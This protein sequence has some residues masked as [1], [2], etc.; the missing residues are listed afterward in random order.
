MRF[1]STLESVD[2]EPFAGTGLATLDVYPDEQEQTESPASGQK[3]PLLT[4]LQKAHARI[5]AWGATLE[6]GFQL[7]D[8][9]IRLVLAERARLLAREPERNAEGESL[10]VVE[11]VLGYER[12]A[13]ESPYV[14]EVYPLRDLTPI[15][16]T[17]AFMLGIVNVRGQLLPVIDL[18]EFLDLQIRER[19]EHAR[20]IVLEAEGVRLGVMADS[21]I[22]VRSIATDSLQASLLTVT[23]LRAEL[24]KGVNGDQLAILDAAA[25]LSD[26]RLVVCA[27]VEG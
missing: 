5:E 20:I 12:Y 2:I 16:C 7:G 14:S 24:L 18:H 10:E 26:E 25:I 17:P 21:I 1:E 22:G 13:F 4:D 11:F 8:E 6:R 9:E 15:P 3:R 19:T 23:G 27:E